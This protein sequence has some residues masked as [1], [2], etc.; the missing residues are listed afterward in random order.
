MASPEPTAILNTAWGVI[1][2]FSC[3]SVPN[4]VAFYTQ[5][6]HFQL[7]G[8]YTANPSHG[9]MC[10]VFIG[11]GAMKG[12]IYL[13]ETPPAEPREGGVAMDQAADDASLGQGGFRPSR[14]AIALGTQAVDQYYELLRREGRVEI[15][16]HVEDKAWGYRQFMVRDMDGNEIQFFR[17][18]DGGNP[19]DGEE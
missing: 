6:L 8:A 4:T 18:L 5:D 13:F 9:A 17:F 15:V 3:R 2:H 12:N 7:G 1:P 11:R 10:S 19:G 14:A 16:E